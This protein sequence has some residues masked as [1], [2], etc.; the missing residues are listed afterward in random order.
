M[1]SSLSAARNTRKLLLGFVTSRS[2]DKSVKVTIP[3][4]TPHPLYHKIINRTYRRAR[5]RREERG[6]GGGQGRDHGD[7]P[8]QTRLK[9]WR[10]VRVTEARPSARRTR[11]CPEADVAAQVPTKP[12]SRPR[13]QPLFVMIQSSLHPRSGRQHRRPPRR[14]DQPHGPEHRHRPHRRHHHRQHQGE[15][16]RCDR[17]KGRGRQGRRRAHEDRGP[18]R[19]RAA[20][21][22]STAMPSSSS[23]ADGN[24]KGTR[25]FGPV[26]RELRAKNFMKIISLAPEVL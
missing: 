16:H 7:P 24:P 1:S 8:A 5:A 3:Y 9:R 2:G 11:P 19:G 10:I 25:I 23:G 12:R 18:P 15:H 20:T 4:K 26:A 21:C 17:E 22:A 13:K 14:H 6:R